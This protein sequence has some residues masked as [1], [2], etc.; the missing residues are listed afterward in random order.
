MQLLSNLDQMYGLGHKFA[1]FSSLIIVKNPPLF[2]LI[3]ELFSLILELFS[4]FKTLQG[5]HFCF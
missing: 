4:L 1:V 2:S 3:L 5:V